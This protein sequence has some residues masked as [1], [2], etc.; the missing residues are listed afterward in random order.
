MKPIDNIASKI[1]GLFGNGEVEG[2][3]PDIAKQV[4]LRLKGAKVCIE[5]GNE[6]GAGFY[7]AGHPS[8]RVLCYRCWVLRGN[9]S[10]NE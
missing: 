4:L 2:M 1:S 6:T 3:K 9:L 7:R 5:C 8:Q 10:G